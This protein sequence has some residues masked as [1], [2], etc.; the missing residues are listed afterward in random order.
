M[1]ANPQAAVHFSRVTPTEQGNLA[2]A[3]SKIKLAIIVLVHQEMW[4][5]IKLVSVQV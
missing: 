2:D 1:S 5:N 4:V 3:E